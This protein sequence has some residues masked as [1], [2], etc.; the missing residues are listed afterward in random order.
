[1]NEKVA[2][3]SPLYQ[4]KKG[5]VNGFDLDINGNRHKLDA[6]FSYSGKKSKN[7]YYGYSITTASIV[8]LSRVE[9]QM[10][11]LVVSAPILHQFI[12]KV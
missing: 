7:P 3:G 6:N 12:G 11:Y 9:N 8:N 2:F 1:M 4:L 5:I 10:K